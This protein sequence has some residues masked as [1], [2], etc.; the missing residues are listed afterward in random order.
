[1]K[2]TANLPSFCILQLKCQVLSLTLLTL[3]WTW[4]TPLS[5][6]LP[7]LILRILDCTLKDKIKSF[8]LSLQLISQLKIAPLLMPQK[9]TSSFQLQQLILRT[10]FLLELLMSQEELSDFLM[11]KCRFQV[12]HFSCF[13]ILGSVLL[14]IQ[15]HPTPPSI[16]LHF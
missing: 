11:Q 15:S 10:A 2:Y 9:T 1:M 3:K 6:K 14:F 16:I 5:P 7:W 12:L 8:E 13:I 4:L